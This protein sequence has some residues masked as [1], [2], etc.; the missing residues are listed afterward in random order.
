MSLAPGQVGVIGERINPTGK[1]K[2][3]EAL[4]TGQRTTT[5]MG[6]AISQQPRPGP[7]SSTSTPVV[8]ETRR[9]RRS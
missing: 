5:S 3:K 4:R 7:T 8:P 1:K 6:E 9:A 2:M